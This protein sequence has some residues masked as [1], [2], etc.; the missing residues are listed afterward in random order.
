M[1]WESPGWPPPPPDGLPGA[2]R[3]RA[4]PDLCCGHSRHSADSTELQLCSPGSLQR[5]EITQP[6]CSAVL[7]SCSDH[8]QECQSSTAAPDASSSTGI[9]ALPQRAATAQHPALLWL[10]MC[11][12]CPC[13][14]Q[15]YS[16]STSEG[17][18]RK[19]Q[20]TFSTPTCSV[21]FVLSWNLTSFPVPLLRKLF[22]CSQNPCVAPWFPL[23][24]VREI[25]GNLFF[26]E[27]G[28]N[29]KETRAVFPW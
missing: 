17:A 26:E 5:E 3:V 13:T 20:L 24:T 1:L 25:I 27:A 10:G 6:A 15:T 11:P 29:S 28:I 9:Q 23:F 22:W 4:W 7:G 12:V 2:V 14:L 18:K 16:T 21:N 8:A 19:L